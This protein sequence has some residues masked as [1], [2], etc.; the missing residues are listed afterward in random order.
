[1]ATAE[2]LSRTVKV[3]GMRYYDVGVDKLFP[4]VTTILGAM[5]DKSGLDK[6]RN[7]VGH[8]KADQIS[9]QAANRGTVMHQ[10][11]EYYLLSSEE[12][13]KAKLREAQEKILAFASEQG[14]SDEEVHIGRKLFYNFYN[15]GSFEQ[16][17]EV[18]SIEE[19]LYCYREGGYAGRVDTIYRKPTGELIISDYKTSKGPKKL[20]WISNYFMQASAY[21]VAY[22][23]MTGERPAGC[24]IWIS[25]EQD[26]EPQIFSMSLADV[27]VH[28][29]KFLALVKA[30]HAQYA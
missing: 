13:S 24:E 1:M 4:S 7:Q 18:V 25:N 11:I 27:K 28:A 20:E 15:S 16:I 2:G 6:W 3:K 29:A 19:T 17:A 30:F 5:T 12:E 9:Q 26:Q 22:W 14:F 21:F 8:E 10:M 23:E